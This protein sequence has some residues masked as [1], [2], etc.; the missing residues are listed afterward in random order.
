MQSTMPEIL[1]QLADAVADAL[2]RQGIAPSLAHNA[3]YES[4]EHIRQHFGGSIIYVPRGLG[5]QLARRNAEIRRRLSEG[6]SRDTIRREFNLTDTQIRRI[7]ADDTPS[8]R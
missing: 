6:E 2:I 4:A 8:R 1:E 3:A 5:Y 7:E